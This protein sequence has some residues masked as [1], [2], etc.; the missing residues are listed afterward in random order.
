M[1]RKERLHFSLNSIILVALVVHGIGTAFGFEDTPALPD[2]LKPGVVRNRA[3][4]EHFSALSKPGWADDAPVVPASTRKLIAACGEGRQ[5]EVKALL[6]AGALANGADERGHRP[7]IA[8]VANGHVEIVRMLLQAGADP[9]VKGPE[10]RRPL[11]LA[12]AAGQGDMVRQLL[13]A[14]ADVNLRSDNRA[15]AVHEAVRFVQTDI[16]QRLLAARPFPDNY[17]REGLHPLALASSLGNLQA[18]RTLL[19]AGIDPDLPDRTGLTA[20]HW[21]RRFQQGLAEAYLIER[22]ATREAW[23]IALN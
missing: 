20:L 16:L 14:G 9:D 2:R 8:A 13:R 17:D 5:D 19:D 22:G 15:T 7:L 6:A 1:E 21:A 23:P 3:L 18:L 4:P 11:G 12:A 10:G